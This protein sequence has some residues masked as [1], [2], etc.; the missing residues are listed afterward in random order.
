M[1]TWGEDWTE[2]RA[3]HNNRHSVPT[4]I[5]IPGPTLPVAGGGGGSNTTHA[6]LSPDPE[7]LPIG[8]V[9]LP[10]TGE[11]L[12][13]KGLQGQPTMT[14]HA[15]LTAGP[16]L[17]LSRRY[18]PAKIPQELVAENGLFQ[19][20]LTLAQKSPKLTPPLDP[21]EVGTR[22]LTPCPSNKNSLEPSPNLVPSELTAS[23][24][25]GFVRCG[26]DAKITKIGL[27][28]T[29][30]PP[31]QRKTNGS[32]DRRQD[33]RLPSE[34]TTWNWV[35]APCGQREM[36][37]PIDHTG[38]V[39]L[40]S[41]KGVILAAQNEPKFR[42]ARNSIS[43]RRLGDRICHS[44]HAPRRVQLRLPCTW[45]PKISMPR[46]VVTIPICPQMPKWQNCPHSLWA[47]TLT[48]VAPLR[49]RGV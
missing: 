26:H 8:G 12:I 36:G 28:L 1:Y 31:G 43:P 5:P 42:G 22:Q 40:G 32:Q 25:H 2:V 39:K 23:G 13:T 27:I 45:L 49:P 18:G 3:S 16:N 35:R 30:A 20:K 10:A 15:P 47:S 7:T 33:L 9:S 38:G 48:K 44:I 6:L 19:P 17:S 11:F 46:G 21:P 14:P 29:R 37:P 41:Q 34:C 24:H 4:H